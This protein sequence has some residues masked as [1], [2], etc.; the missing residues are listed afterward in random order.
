[1]FDNTYVHY[2]DVCAELITFTTE[3]FLDK[4]K[5][6]SNS[7]SVMATLPTDAVRLA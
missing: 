5:T 1:M 2:M 3:S 7:L 6:K 4:T